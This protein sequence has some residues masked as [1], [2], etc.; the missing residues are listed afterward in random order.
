MKEKIARSYL[1]KSAGTVDGLSGKKYCHI[2]D[3]EG[4]SGKKYDFFGT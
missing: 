3:K 1:K 4:L 2:W